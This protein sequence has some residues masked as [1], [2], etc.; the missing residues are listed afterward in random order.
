[1]KEIAERVCILT[2]LNVKVMWVGV[3][4]DTYSRKSARPDFQGQGK[5]CFSCKGVD[6]MTFQDPGQRGVQLMGTGRDF[7]LNAASSRSEALRE[8]KL[9]QLPAHRAFG[10]VPGRL[11]C[12][13]D[14][15]GHASSRWDFFGTDV[16]RFFPPFEPGLGSLRRALT[17][18]LWDQ[19]LSGSPGP[20]GMPTLVLG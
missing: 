6:K 8:S 18:T 11:V 5:P 16:M 20:C 7:F 2:V 10:D 14:E 12:E 4:E 3:D 1:M 15:P 13:E 17:S 19:T 9:L